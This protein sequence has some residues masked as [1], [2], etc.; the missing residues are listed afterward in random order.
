VNFV[1]VHQARF[2]HTNTHHGNCTKEITHMHLSICGPICIEKVFVNCKIWVWGVSLS[3]LLL[4]KLE[5]LQWFTSPCS[6]NH[7]T[8]FEMHMSTYLCS[9]SPRLHVRPEEASQ[10]LE[11]TARGGLDPQ[12]YWRR[13]CPS[14]P[15]SA[16]TSWAK[17][18]ER[19]AVLGPRSGCADPTPFSF[20]M[21]MPFG[22]LKYV[23]FV[24][25]VKALLTSC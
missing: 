9:S 3:C 13:Q 10:H 16:P 17:E 21:F 2:T 22:G 12:L 19:R 18:R 15:S 24:H 11:S 25:K 1:R 20:F 4:L 6:M 14:T 5:M 7:P 23:M 8:T